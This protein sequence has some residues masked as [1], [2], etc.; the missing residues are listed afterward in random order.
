MHLRKLIPVT[1]VTVQTENW[2]RLEMEAKRQAACDSNIL[3]LQKIKYSNQ[4]IVHCEPGSSYCE[5]I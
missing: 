5:H 3:I 1:V 2:R 4:L